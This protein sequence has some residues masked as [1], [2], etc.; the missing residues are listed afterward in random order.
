MPKFN[1]A[2]PRK[3]GITMKNRIINLFVALALVLMFSLS[4]NQAQAEVKW[5]EDFNVPDIDGLSDDWWLDGYSLNGVFA[6]DDTAFP[7]IESDMLKMPNTRT[8]GTWSGIRRNSTVA[9]GT[10]SFDWTVQNGTDHNSAD[11]IM[12][13]INNMPWNMTGSSPAPPYS[14]YGYFLVL[15]SSSSGPWTHLRTRSITL[16]EF[17]P[18]NEVVLKDYQFD[19]TITGS[20]HI[21]VTRDQEGEFKVFFDS[22]LLF[23]HT[24]K[25]TT[26]SESCIFGSWIGDSTFDNIVVRDDVVEITT[27]TSAPSPVPT[28]GFEFVVILSPLVLIALFV[29]TDSRRGR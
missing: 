17:I 3:M 8:F 4:V 24:D 12:L 28:I 6:P 25:T 23:N 2:L 1:V 10:W 5:S 15:R 11:V 27:P 26:T 19:E 9:Y 14:W 21:D 18:N 16:S 29:M 20:H 13:M 22:V 7:T